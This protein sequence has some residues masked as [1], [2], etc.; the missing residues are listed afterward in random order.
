MNRSTSSHNNWG[1]T[2]SPNAIPA[3]CARIPPESN[4]LSIQWMLTPIS[5]SPF[6][7]AQLT[8]M[9]PRYFGSIDVCTL[10]APKF[11][12]RS[13]ADGSFQGKP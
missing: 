12:D 7:I 13:T 2:S 5:L 8:G 3:S 6:L 11:V 10:M 1:A 9:G 4:S